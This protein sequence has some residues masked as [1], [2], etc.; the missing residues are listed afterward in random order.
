MKA[1][2]RWSAGTLSLLL[3]ASFS[4]AQ[5]RIWVSAALKTPLPIAPSPSNSGFYYVDG[6]GRLVGPNWYLTPPCP[7]FN[8]MLPGPIGCAIMSGNL[9]HKLLLNKEAMTLGDAPLLQ[10]KK[11]GRQ[12]PPEPRNGPVMPNTPQMGPYSLTPQASGQVPY[13]GP[14]YYTMPMT[15]PPPVAHAPM[16][17]YAPV[18]YAP[19]AAYGQPIGYVPYYGP[20]GMIATAQRDP[21]TGIWQ[22]QNVAPSPFMPIPNY[23]G[24][25]GAMP[26]QSAPPQGAFP[27]YGPAP[28]GGVPFFGPMQSMQSMQPMNQFGPLQ[29]PRPDMAGLQLPRMEGYGPP[30]PP[31]GP[32][33]M[34]PVHPFTRSPRDFFMWGDSIED[35]RARGSRPM[36]V[37]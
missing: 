18:S 25:P 22:V 27:F 17:P 35:E 19:G 8:G 3:L 23:P 10:S 36:P 14:P 33:G 34:Y 20:P 21:R 30:P 1:I 24:T 12:G 29:G 7:P 28:Q 13:Y 15:A 11:H 31:Q 37:P 6:Y 32:R 26:T 2:L 5:D 16:M 9:P 4:Q